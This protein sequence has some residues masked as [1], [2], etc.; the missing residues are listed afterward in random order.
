MRDSNADVA[1]S[2]NWKTLI[3]SPMLSAFRHGIVNAHT[4]DLPRYRGNATPNWAIL[5][6]ENE[7][8]LTLHRMV[9]ELDAGPILGRAS[10]AIDDHTYIADVYAFEDDVCPGLF[11]DVLDGLENGTLEPREQDRAGALRCYRGSRATT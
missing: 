9:E 6:G 4:G 11:A 7:I 2:V 10:L 8:V 1:I 3:R 5:R